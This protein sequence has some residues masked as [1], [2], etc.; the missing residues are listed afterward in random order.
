M[1]MSD[2][3][4]RTTMYMSR[5]KCSEQVWAGYHT[6]VH[7]QFVGALYSCQQSG[8]KRTAYPEPFFLV[9][10]RCVFPCFKGVR[11]FPRMYT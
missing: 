5:V 3:H 9:L 1:T 11:N 6:V 7:V 8:R 4:V 10:K 2:V